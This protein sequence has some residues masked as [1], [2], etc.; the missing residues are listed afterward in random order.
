MITMLALLTLT[1]ASI[2]GQLKGN[3]LYESLSPSPVQVNPHYA[4]FI[5]SFDMSHV[6]KGFQT[7]QTYTHMYIAI[8]DKIA[9]DNKRVTNPV[10]TVIDTS[11]RN[12]TVQCPNNMSLPEIKSNEEARHLVKLMETYKIKFQRAGLYL[13][14]QKKL[15]YISNGRINKY[16]RINCPMCFIN[17]LFDQRNDFAHSDLYYFL[18]DNADLTI[19]MSTPQGDKNTNQIC[20]ENDFGHDKQILN[21]LAIQACDRDINF[22]EMITKDLEEELEEFISPN[23]YLINRKKRKKRAFFLPL[24]AKGIA[25]LGGGLA[26]KGITGTNP[27]HAIGKFAGSAFGLTTESD[28]EQVRSILSKNTI[29]LENIKLNEKEISKAI[30]E[31]AERTNRLTHFV[32]YQLHDIMAM[33]SEIDAK[34][35]IRLL[36]TTLQNILMKMNLAVQA[37][38]HSLPSP[39]VLTS[40]ELRNLTAA[41]KLEKIMLTNNIDDVSMAVII[42]DG[43]YKFVMAVPLVNEK[44]AFNLYEVKQLPIFANH[45]TYKYQTLTNYIGINYETDEYILLTATEYARCTSRP[46]CSFSGSLN[47]F[48]KLAPCEVSSF[49]YNKTD[50][51]L[52][53]IPFG[54]H[55]FFTYGNVTYFSVP[56]KMTVRVKC[57]FRNEW[58]LDLENIGFFDTPLICDVHT[59]DEQQIRHE[60]VA[61]IA[62]LPDKVLFKSVGQL[63]LSSIHYP[64]D[65]KFNSTGMKPMKFLDLPSLEDQFKTIFDPNEGSLLMTRIAFTVLGLFLILL[66]VYF[67]SKCFRAW[68]NNCCSFSKPHHYWSDHKEYTN[69]PVYV[70]RLA[71]KKTLGN[72]IKEF[73]SSISRYRK[74]PP[75][76]QLTDQENPF[77]VNDYE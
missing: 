4:H 11:N 25:V 71:A 33:F 70:K 38:K 76:R 47:K 36:Q 55:T 43:T 7:L 21:F 12:E 77:K 6:I 15:R 72:K 51:D 59:T 54:Q 42:I 62:H 5:R 48:S 39:Y 63:D 17:H 29:S 44:N 34:S 60:Y 46:T 14:N 65:E 2:E 26:Y 61:K 28:L 40:Q 13:D 9:L 69:V 50:C 23:T 19:M 68:F 20:Y 22:L 41:H 58:T 49:V 75:N 24:V 31:L 64:M 73:K 27:L 8:C 10:L 32:N 18:D 52:E 56:I 53:E 16:N 1:S 35:T 57:P 67:S 45:K 66:V 37:A 3:I 30:N 74:S